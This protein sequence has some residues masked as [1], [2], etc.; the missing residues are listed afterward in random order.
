MLYLLKNLFKFWSLESKEF[1]WS[2]E[3]PW[4][5]Y[6]VVSKVACS[7]IKKTFI[8]WEVKDDYSIHSKNLSWTITTTSKPHDAKYTFTFVRNPFDRLVSAYKSKFIKDLEIPW[9]KFEYEK[10]LFWIF[11]KDESFES[12]VDKVCNIPDWLADRHFK[13]QYSCVYT[14]WKSLVDFVGKFESIN[15]DFM[16]FQEN[17]GLWTLGQY[18]VTSKNWDNY[19]KRFTSKKMVDK[20][21]KRY[22]RDIEVF[23]YTKQHK[24]L[25]DKFIS[26][27]IHE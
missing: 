24:K 15:N 12:F 10:Y 14:H 1:F 3:F 20:V 6:L 16:S 26:E 21:A 25:V 4:I 8:K 7:S 18:N 23:W 27:E 2:K 22:A 13:S 17:H 9:K 11:N 19:A 5:Y